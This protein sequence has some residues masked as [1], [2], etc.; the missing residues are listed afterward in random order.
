MT[1]GSGVTTSVEARWSLGMRIPLDHHRHVEVGGDLFDD[2]D[3]L[4]GVLEVVERREEDE[5]VAGPH[6]DRQRG[7][8][9]LVAVDLFAAGDRQL[10]AGRERVPGLER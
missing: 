10:G 1:P 9:C 3:Q 6:L 5:Q 4:D 8:W 2:G 7:R